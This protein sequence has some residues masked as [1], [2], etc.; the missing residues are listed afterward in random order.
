MLKKYYLF[1]AIGVQ[2]IQYP[3]DSFSSYMAKNI[4]STT[5]KILKSIFIFL[6]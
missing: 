4:T 5:K 6:K 2:G 1:Y 3:S